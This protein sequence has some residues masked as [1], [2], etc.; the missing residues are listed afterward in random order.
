MEEIIQTEQTVT[1][2]ME[3]AVEQIPEKKGRKYIWLI[4]L[5]VV[6]AAAAVFL[7][8]GKLRKYD[9]AETLFAQKDYDA[10]AQIFEELANYRDSA[11]RTKE[12]RYAQARSWMAQAQYAQALEVFESLGDYKAARYQLQQCHFVLGETAMEEGAYDL[13]IEHFTN[14]QSTGTAPQQKLEAIYARGHELFLDGE[15][16]TAQTY[17]DQLEG[18]WPQNGGPH[19]VKIDEALD[20][21]EVQA[22]ELVESVTLVVKD[23]PGSY[24]MVD[25]YL[26]A[27]I[28]QYMGYQYAEVTY[29]EKEHIVTVV[30]DYYPGQRI[31]W[32]WKHEDLSRLD[33]A[34]LQAYE[35]AVD[36]V[37]QAKAEVG[38]DDLMALELWLHD[39]ICDNVVYHSP[40]T[41][42]NVED[43]VGLRELTCVGAFLDGDV[44]CQ[45]YTDAFYVLGTMAGMEI[46]KV[47]GAS[48][49]GHCWNAIWLN[50]W[51]YTVDV[52]YAD[53]ALGDDGEQLYVWFNNALSLDEYMVNGGVIQFYKMA[54]RKDL[55][56]TYYAY[57]GRVY[58]NMD[59]AAYELLVQY[60]KNGSGSYQAVV[61]G[62]WDADDFYDS[63]GNTMGRAGVYNVQWQLWPVSYLGDTYLYLQ[64]M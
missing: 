5:C 37:E 18:Q 3:T 51:L 41:Y 25:N 15:Y 59:D 27:T 32:A 62:Q 7:C 60:R 61:E 35:V 14:A 38:S 57:N 4:C 49:E 46:Y 47:F 63:V 56:Q 39:W 33:E 22:E 17:F 8:T 6:I 24:I 52:T 1:Q 34:E 43:Y 54:T 21:L 16:Q 10:A 58:E 19:F 31:L 55:S 30:P 53:T 48:E 45:G 12:V 28:K 13:A 64:W 42:V 23:M 44:N 36:L 26:N 11:L 50:D 9:Q 29:D 20:Y 2:E 40:S